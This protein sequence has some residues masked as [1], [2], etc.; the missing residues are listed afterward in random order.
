MKLAQ[1]NAAVLQKAGLPVNAANLYMLHQLGPAAGKEVIQGAASGKSTSQLS[2][3]TQKAMGMNV[4]A[5][6]GTAADYLAK[7]AAALDSRGRS[8]VGDMSQLTATVP[9]QTVAQSA[10]PPPAPIPPAPPSPAP[11]PPVQANIPQPMNSQG[12]VDVRVSGDKSI[13]QDLGDKRLA[14]IATGG[15]AV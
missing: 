4:G 12:P 11:T 2:P 10:P 15:I 6:S 9:V 13:G 3:E 14:Q 1:E 5:G 7:N 8:V